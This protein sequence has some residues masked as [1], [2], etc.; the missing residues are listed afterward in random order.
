MNYRLNS[1]EAAYIGGYIG[2]YYRG[3]EGGHCEFR[4][5][6]SYGGRTQ[7]SRFGMSSVLLGVKVQGVVQYLHSS[8]R[9]DLVNKGLQ[10]V[11]VS[12]S[13]RTPL[14]PT[15]FNPK[16]RD[17]PFPLNP[18]SSSWEPLFMGTLI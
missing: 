2:D 12:R 16:Y 13:R 18:K 17:P 10:H 3:Y 15:P 6:G 1:V 7:L 9:E 11:V 4:A 5:Y 14:T 8:T